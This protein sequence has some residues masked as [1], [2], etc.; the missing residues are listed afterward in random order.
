VNGVES[1][2]VTEN[3]KYNYHCTTSVT[4]IRSVV[5]TTGKAHI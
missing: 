2:S 1:I 4:E 3:G 5:F